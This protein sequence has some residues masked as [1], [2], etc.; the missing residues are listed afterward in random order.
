M[1]GGARYILATAMVLT[2]KEDGTTRKD[3]FDSRKDG[4][5]RKDGTERSTLP[6]GARDGLR[7]TLHFGITDLMV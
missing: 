5:T 6:F 3:G 2:T 4:T 1:R 7:T